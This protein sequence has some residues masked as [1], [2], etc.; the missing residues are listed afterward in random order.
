MVCVPVC[1]SVYCA[2]FP[3]SALFYPGLFIGL[4]FFFF[5]KRAGK[6]E[7][8]EL[9]EGENLGGNMGGATMIRICC[10]KIIFKK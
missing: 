6:I 4:F 2:L 8:L 7:G 10:M 3:L 9:G 1:V 5:L